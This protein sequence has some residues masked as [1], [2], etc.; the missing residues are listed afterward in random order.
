[1]PFLSY[2]VRVCALNVTRECCCDLGHLAEVFARRILSPVPFGRMSPWPPHFRSGGCALPPRGQST[3]TRYLGFFYMRCV[4]SP[5]L[6]IHHFCISLDLW[7]SIL[8]FGLCPNTMSLTLLFS[9][10]AVAT[11]ALTHPSLPGC[12]ESTVMLSGPCHVPHSIS[13]SD[14]LHTAHMMVVRRLQWS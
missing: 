10:P 14:R 3:F 6:F 13:G 12:L 8:Y 5:L 1:M 9:V 4:S 2:D 11:G 7:M